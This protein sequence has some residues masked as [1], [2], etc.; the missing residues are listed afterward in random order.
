MKLFYLSKRGND[1]LDRASEGH[2]QGKIDDAMWRDI[3]SVLYDGYEAANDKIEEDL[4]R[5]GA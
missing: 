4:K 3:Q 5:A 2:K 1:L